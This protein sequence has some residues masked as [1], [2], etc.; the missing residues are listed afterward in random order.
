MGSYL[1]PNVGEQ[2]V[3]SAIGFLEEQGLLTESQ[4]WDWGAEGGTLFTDPSR[5]DAECAALYATFTP[6][7]EYR[8]PIPQALRDHRQH[9]LDYY[10]ADPAVITTAQTVHVVKDII[11]VLYY[12]NQRIQT[13]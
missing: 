6:Q 5:T 13:D 8:Q 3:A 4:V 1:I 7:A 2:E 10:N 12:L 9:L 11:R